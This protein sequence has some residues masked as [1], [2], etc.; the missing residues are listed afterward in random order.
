MAVVK[1]YGYV[2][3]LRLK[4]LNP[5]QFRR[6]H[7]ELCLLE[8]QASTPSGTAYEIRQSIPYELG[9]YVDFGW[10]ADADIERDTPDNAVPLTILDEPKFVAAEG[11]HL[12]GFGR[13]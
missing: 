11:Y 8:A 13:T 6:L 5:R 10:V 3:S 4:F 9:R 1:E 7:C 2:K 12:I